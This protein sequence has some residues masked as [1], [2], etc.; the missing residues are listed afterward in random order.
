MAVVLC[1]PAFA[2]NETQL[3]KE[4]TSDSSVNSVAPL[5]VGTQTDHSWSYSYGSPRLKTSGE[6]N[7]LYTGEPAQRDGEH[8]T[9]SHSTA[10]TSSFSGTFGG[11]I[12]SKIEL[13]LQVSFSK[14]TE[15]Q[16]SKNSASLK[17]GEYIKAYWIKTFD[18]YDV[19]QKD[20]QHTYGFEQ[21][22]P[23]GPYEKVDRYNTVY[24]HVTVDKAIQ[25][26]IRLEYWK[27][28]KRVKSADSEDTLE[29]IEYY[30]WKNGTY[31]MVCKEEK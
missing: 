5:Y 8:D 15:F 19:T 12:K 20:L 22:Y 21:K 24:S 3:N 26:K 14:T 23:G 4:N 7:H 18:S 25:P 17:R 16:V 9:V 6:W 13:D 28:G 27:N 2:A 1:M 10:Y 29:R 30:E 11:N 31:Q